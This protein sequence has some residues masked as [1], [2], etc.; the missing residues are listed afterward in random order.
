M[1][2]DKPQ[3]QIQKFGL[4]IIWFESCRARISAFS[5]SRKTSTSYRHTDRQPHNP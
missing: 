4:R 5:H 1:R 2:K 3:W